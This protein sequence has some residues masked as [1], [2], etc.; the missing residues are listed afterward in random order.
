MK[1]AILYD[2]M[3]NKYRL[4]DSASLEEFDNLTVD[5]VIDEPD[6]DNDKVQY[7]RVIAEGIANGAFPQEIA[8]A[9]AE[10]MDLTRTELWILL[11]RAQEYFD[12]IKANLPGKMY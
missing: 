12:E 5:Y 9:M 11:D 1:T 10:S 4:E 7:A 2:E 3:G 6:W 8:D